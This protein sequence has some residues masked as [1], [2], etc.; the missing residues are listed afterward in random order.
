MGLILRFD[1]KDNVVESSLIFSPEKPEDVFGIVYMWA[2]HVDPDLTDKI[3]G[4][5]DDQTFKLKGAGDRVSQ[6]YTLKNLKIEVTA[7]Y[8]SGVPLV[9][10]VASKKQ[11]G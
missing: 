11:R 5:I 6:D 4:W 1:K 9:T 10:L 7:S 3:M 2:L 8:I